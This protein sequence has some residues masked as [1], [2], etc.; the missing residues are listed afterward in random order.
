MSIFIKVKNVSLDFP[1][2]EQN[3]FSFRNKLTSFGKL[4]GEEG[5][6]NNIIKGL[7]NINI[8]FNEGDKVAI[9]GANGS[10]KTTL[11]KLLSKIYSPSTG[12][13]KIN[14]NICSMID[15]GFGFLEDASGIENI[16]LSKVIRGESIENEEK[17]IKNA[18]N[19]SGLDEY[20]KLP[21]R[22]Y[23]SGMKSR[24]AL[25]TAL[26]SNPDILLIDE[27]FSTG[28]IEFAIKSKVK[29]MEIIDKSAIL[30]FASHNLDVIE[31][32]CNKAIYMKNGKIE[33]YGGVGEIKSIYIN[34][35]L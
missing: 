31:D 23:S 9:I 35:H 27:F 12:E 5:K 26:D 22:T 4:K 7:D 28:D 3:D 18:K 1:L 34:D 14:G 33:N 11:L 32:I 13:V 19:F 29:I 10:G 30:L 17:I 21:I 6:K 20:I 24:L 15:L 25:A 16:L 8:E 2:Y